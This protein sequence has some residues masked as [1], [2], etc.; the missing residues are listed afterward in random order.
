MDSFINISFIATYILLGLAVAALVVFP[1]Y[2]LVTNFGKAKGGL[3]GLAA[4]LVVVAI[5]IGVSPVDQ[6]EKFLNAGISPF[7]SQLIGG[8]LLTIYIL[9][10]GIILAAVYTEISKW[11]K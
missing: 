1:L 11:F 4:I 8:G 6:S 3:I 5:A 9:F 7:T 10:A 2:A